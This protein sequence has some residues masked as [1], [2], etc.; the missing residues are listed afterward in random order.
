MKGLLFAASPLDV[1]YYN[2][3]FVWCVVIVPLV[4]AG[5]AGTIHGLRLLL[6]LRLNTDEQPPA[7]TTADEV[8]SAPCD[9]SR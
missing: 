3:T 5:I 9:A 2:R 6:R 1:G 7:I 8:T 4:I